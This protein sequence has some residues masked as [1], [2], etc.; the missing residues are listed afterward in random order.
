MIVASD[1]H[2]GVFAVLRFRWRPV[3]N[4]GSRKEVKKR[5]SHPFHWAHDVDQK[6]GGLLRAAPV[7]IRAHADPRIPRRAV[8]QPWPE[9]PLPLQRRSA[10]LTRGA[11]ADRINAL[12]R[13]V[14]EG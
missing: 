10:P 8:P 11:R 7:A 4:T 13:A 1:E 9:R 6:L 12:K 3:E 5:G 2:H 14:L